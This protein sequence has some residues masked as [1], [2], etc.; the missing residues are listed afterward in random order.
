MDKPHN[1]EAGAEQ[2]A[3]IGSDRPVIE[4]ARKRGERS[5]VIRLTLR[6]RLYLRSQAGQYDSMT[7]ALCGGTP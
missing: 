2:G 4:Q 3:K 6:N 1:A 7:T 5:L